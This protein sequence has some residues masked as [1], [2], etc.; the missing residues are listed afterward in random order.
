MNILKSP[1][2]RLRIIAFLEGLSFIALLGIA[3]PLKYI[4]GYEHATQEVGMAHG[5]LFLSYVGLLYPMRESQGWTWKQIAIAFIASLLPFGT[6]IA[7]YRW[8]RKLA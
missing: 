1:L 7:E 4:Y 6:F 8:F 3:V 2:G 5:V